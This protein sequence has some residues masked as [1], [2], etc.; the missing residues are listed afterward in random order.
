MQSAW[1]WW[2]VI[3]KKKKKNIIKRGWKIS[4]PDLLLPR[5]T[6]RMHSHNLL[7]DILEIK[8]YA[9]RGM[10]VSLPHLPERHPTQ[11]PCLP[12]PR[13]T[14]ELAVPTHS[15]PQKPCSRFRVHTDQP[16]FEP[17]TTEWALVGAYTELKMKKNGAGPE[18][19]EVGNGIPEGR[20]G[21]Q[22]RSW[23]W[24]WASLA[25]FPSS[26]KRS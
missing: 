20:R 23:S 4:G 2:Y 9:Q 15:I 10:S 19:R 21:E 16:G 24:S 5:E 17:R 11:G 12:Q 14:W 22:I 7:I 6:F 26:L 1:T 3:W 18:A 13:V 8:Y 25:L